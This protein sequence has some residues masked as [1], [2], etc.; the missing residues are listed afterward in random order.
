[1][2]LDW[3][4]M[5]VAAGGVVTLLIVLVSFVRSL[6]QNPGEQPNRHQ[7]IREIAIFWYYVVAAGVL[8]YL[9]LYVVPRF[10]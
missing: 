8:T 5:L 10:I 2:V 4:Q 7:S 9:L 3:F 6:Q 1:M